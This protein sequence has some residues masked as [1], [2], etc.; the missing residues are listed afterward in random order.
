MTAQPTQPKEERTLPAWQVYRLID[1][2]T[3]NEIAI[4]LLTKED[5]YS[6]NHVADRLIARR[7]EIKHTILKACDPSYDPN[8][9]EED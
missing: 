1:E 5:N 2:L 9:E 6:T 7:I 8:N 3:E 4:F